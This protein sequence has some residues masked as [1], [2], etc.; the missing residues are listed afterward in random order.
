LVP[1]FGCLPCIVLGFQMS[2][3]S[4][5]YIGFADGAIHGTQNLVSVSWETYAPTDELIS[6]HGVFLGH[7]NNNIAENSAFIELLTDVVSLGIH[8]IIV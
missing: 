6:L 4:I 3:S 7:A 8:H 5:T 2:L 1:P